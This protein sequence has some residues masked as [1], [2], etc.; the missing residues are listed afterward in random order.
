LPAL[1]GLDE[2][3]AAAPWLLG[4]RISVLEIAWF[5]SVHQLAMVTCSLERHPPLR[6]H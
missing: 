3:L 5:I 4:D 6:A 2:R 1:D